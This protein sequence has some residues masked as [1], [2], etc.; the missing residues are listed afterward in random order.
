[1]KLLAQHL[2]ERPPTTNWAPKVVFFRGRCHLEYHRPRS[3][4]GAPGQPAP[5][6]QHNWG[7]EPQ[8]NTFAGRQVLHVS[9]AQGGS[10]ER[11]QRHTARVS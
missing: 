10:R 9:D 6:V 4:N 7:L 3:E 5:P 2:L 8:G 11:A 1:M